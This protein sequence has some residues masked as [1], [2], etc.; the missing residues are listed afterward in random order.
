MTMVIGDNDIRRYEEDGAICLRGVIEPEWLDCLREATERAVDS[1]GMD[2][3]KKGQSGKF[4]GDLNMF[5]K[6]PDFRAFAFEGPSWQIAQTLMRST[7]VRLFSDQLF[8]KEPG[9]S[10][11]TPWHHDQTYWPVT[12]DHVCSVWVTMD[13]VTSETSGLEYVRGSHRWG[14]RFNPEDFG[15]MSLAMLHDAANETMPDIDAD[16]DDYDFLSWDMEP[17]D[18][19]VHHSLAVHGAGGNRSSTQRRR[20]IS[21]RWF[22]DQA[23]FRPNGPFQPAMVG[24]QHGEP[25]TSPMFPLLPVAVGGEAVIATWPGRPPE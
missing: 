8:V 24:L 10:T 5:H 13:P 18:C 20:A 4:I 9:T 7:A 17:G 19:L 6:D 14:R 15:E 22:G 16:R 12:G 23:Y 21:T 11:P 2:M 3:N 25:M 1:G